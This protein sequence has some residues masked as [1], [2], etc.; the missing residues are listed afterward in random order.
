MSR[1][2]AIQH[3]YDVRQDRSMHQVN[4]APPTD[5]VVSI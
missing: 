4:L 5:P 1:Q 2:T 3:R